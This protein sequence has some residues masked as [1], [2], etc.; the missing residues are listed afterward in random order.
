MLLLINEENM[1]Y[2]FETTGRNDEIITRINIDEIMTRVVSSH[3]KMSF[4]SKI[5]L[6][7]L[8]WLL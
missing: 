1:E 8:C 2:D 3:D 5:V 6:S 4:I 7:F